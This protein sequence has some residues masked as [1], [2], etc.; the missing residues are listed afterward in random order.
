LKN[1]LGA[2]DLE[3]KELRRKVEVGEKNDM[4]LQ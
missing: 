2:L 4:I 3:L 1:E